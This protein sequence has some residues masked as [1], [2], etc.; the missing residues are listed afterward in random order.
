MTVILG[1]IGTAQNL[2]PVERLRY[3]GSRVA[4]ESGRRPRAASGVAS[5]AALPY[6]DAR[7]RGS[8]GSK[9]R[10]APPAGRYIAI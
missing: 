5:M 7:P 9:S 10:P 4:T 8:G 6:H 2:H 1:H 3:W